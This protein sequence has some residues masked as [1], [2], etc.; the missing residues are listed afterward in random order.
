[1]TNPDVWTTIHGLKTPQLLYGTAWKKERTAALVTEAIQSGFRGIDTA[2]Q[3]KH[4]HEKGVGEGMAAALQSMSLTRDDLYLQSKFTSLGGQ[5]LQRIPY[6]PQA[7]LSTQVSQSFQKSLDNLQTSYLD[8]LVLHSPLS[9]FAKT[10]TVWRAMERLF[11]AGLVKRLG[12]SN[13]Y[14]LKLFSALYQTA[15]VKPVILQNRFY[16]D[17]HYDFQLRRFCAQQK[18]IYQS[19]WTL[20][21]NPHI[22]RHHLLQTLQQKYQRTQAQILFRYLSQRGIVPLTG[23]TS[24][25][26]MEEDLAISMF[27]LSSEACDELDAL[28]T[29]SFF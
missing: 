27:E 12:I 15:K 10:K 8:A 23:T 28:F 3:P 16:A 26:H 24:R 18:I 21:A 6:D 25:I 17:T 7:D 20:T 4:Y 2:C 29:R 9:T 22:L 14:D 11:E 5:D 13:C 19:F 1:M